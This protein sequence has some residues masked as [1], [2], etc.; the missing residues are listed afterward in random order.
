[1]GEIF[2]RRLWWFVALIA[3]IGFS[4]RLAAAQGGLWLDEAWSA[5][6]ADQA[7]SPLGILLRVNHDNNHHLNSL[8][9]QGVGL[10]APW[11]L[12]RGLSIIAGTATIIV[13]AIIGARRNSATAIVA[14]LLFALSPILVTYGSEARGYAPMLLALLT[15]VLLVDRW[16]ADPSAHRPQTALAVVALIGLLAQLT[17]AF[18]LVA[19]VIWAAWRMSRQFGPHAGLACTVR[20]FLPAACVAVLT[21]ASIMFTASIASGGMAIGA[22]SPFALTSWGHGLSQLLEYAFGHV[23]VFLFA[24]FLAGLT[25]GYPRRE[26]LYSVVMIG[27]VA[28]PLMVAIAMLPN[29]GLARYYLL[30]GTAALLFVAL[31]VGASLSGKRRLPALLALFLLCG[32]MLRLDWIIIADQRADPARALTAIAHSAPAGTDVATDHPRSEAILH[33]AAAQARYPLTIRQACPATRFLFVERDG[34]AAFPARPLHCGSNYR[35]VA[36]DRVEALSGTQWT[37]Y[38]RLP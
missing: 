9:L 32:S 6:M 37:L 36:R 18:G 12:Q 20:I 16:L 7:G 21:F 11:W 34:H 19:L 27:G 3:A 26:R 29:A 24:I 25:T 13:A 22:V 35:E 28:F 30:S 10:D 31:L 33:V 5:V 1:M 14:A 8:W 38:E 15:G 2:E 4:L 17:M 23:G